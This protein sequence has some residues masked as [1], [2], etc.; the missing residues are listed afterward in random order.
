MTDAV[1]TNFSKTLDLIPHH[2][3]LTK[4]VSTGVD[5]RVIIWLEEFL[6]GRSHKVKGNE[7][8]HSVIHKF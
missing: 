4:I 6:L 1:I 7:Q 3:L 5:L 8:L 2:R